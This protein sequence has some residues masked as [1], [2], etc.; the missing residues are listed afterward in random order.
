MASVHVNFNYSLLNLISYPYW[1]LHFISDPDN[2]EAM[3]GASTFVLTGVLLRLN[4]FYASLTK[5]LH[6][7]KRSRKWLFSQILLPAFFVSI[8]MSVALSA[9]QIGNLPALILSPSQYHPLEYPKGNFIPYANEALNK[10]RNYRIY[11]SASGDAGP[12]QLTATLKYPAGVGAT[13]VLKTPFNG[14]LDLLVESLNYSASVD[15]T[16]KYYD[17]MCKE[18]FQ[19]G[20][21]PLSNY[22]PQPPQLEKEKSEFDGEYAVHHVGITCTS[23]G[24][25]M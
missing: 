14:T 10:R 22:V 4:Q 5:R 17:P 1:L 19:K 23:Y 20:T 11:R 12:T 25:H 6:Y 18:S 2:N 7:T 3:E 21:S 16:E 24:Y 9:P 8:A 13:C 15:L